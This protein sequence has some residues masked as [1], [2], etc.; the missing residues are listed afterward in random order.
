MDLFAIPASHF[1]SAFSFILPDAG[2]LNIKTLSYFQSCFLIFSLYFT[3]FFL[4]AMALIYLFSF[5]KNTQKY[6]TRYLSTLSYRN[7]KIKPVTL[8]LATKIVEKEFE[9]LGSNYFILEPDNS[10]PPKGNTETEPKRPKMFSFSKQQQTRQKIKKLKEELNASKIEIVALETERL[11]LQE[12]VEGIN[13]LWEVT[14]AELKDLRAKHQSLLERALIVSPKDKSGKFKN[15]S[16]N[17][18]NNYASHKTI[19]PDVQFIE[20]EMRQDLDFTSQEQTHP[21][22]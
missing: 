4:V 17:P 1:I 10:S 16:I 5:L 14:S 2:N 6:L 8:A 19:S 7:E 21:L 15:P 3:G 12:E 9:V 20:Q 13:H 11:K 22:T 18:E